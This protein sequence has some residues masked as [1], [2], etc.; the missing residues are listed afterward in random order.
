LWHNP[1]EAKRMGQ[2]ARRKFEENHT[3][4]HLAQRV[5]DIALQVTGRQSG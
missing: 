1:D 4:D 3:I 5:Y 2:A